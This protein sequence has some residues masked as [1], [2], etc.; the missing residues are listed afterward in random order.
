MIGVSSKGIG[1][2]PFSVM[3]GDQDELDPDPKV[4]QGSQGPQGVVYKM[5]CMA[6]IVKVNKV[7]CQTLKSERIIWYRTI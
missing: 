5:L 1:H 3:A 7:M 6:L 2:F 4:V